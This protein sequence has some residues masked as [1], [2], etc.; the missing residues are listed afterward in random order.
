M[1]F[2][3]VPTSMTLKPKNMGFKW[4]FCYFRVRR[5]LRVNLHW[6]ILEIDQDNLRTKLNWCFWHVSWALAQISCYF[7]FCSMQQRELNVHCV[8]RRWMLAILMVQLH[9]VTHA[10][11]VTSRLWR[12]CCSV[13]QTSILSSAFILLHCMKLF[14][15]VEHSSSRVTA[16]SVVCCCFE[17]GY[18]PCSKKSST[19]AHIHNS[20]NSQRIFIIPSL[21]HSLENLR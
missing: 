15:E 3:E 9:C 2:P 19:P 14:P 4:F 7:S 10:I 8:G 11:K 17:C 20:V 16:A 12:F 6:N 1:S 18:T 21:A 5:T 13:V